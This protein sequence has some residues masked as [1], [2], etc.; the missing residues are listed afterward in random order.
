MTQ[1]QYTT[2][3]EILSLRIEGINGGRIIYRSCDYCEII[4]NTL[5]S[6]EMEKIR[7]TDPEWDIHCPKLDFKQIAKLVSSEMSEKTAIRHTHDLINSGYLH[8]AI[9][10][11]IKNETFRITKD[12][13]EHIPLLSNREEILPKLYEEA[14]KNFADPRKRR[15]IWVNIVKTLYDLPLYSPGTKTLIS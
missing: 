12:Q 6:Y 14:K 13:I 3:K 11:H 1:N 15:K 8:E 5:I 9:D 2:K 7:I 4:L 10:I